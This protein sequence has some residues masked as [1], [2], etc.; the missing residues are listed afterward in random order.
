MQPREDIRVNS[1]SE[2]G[3]RVP[4]TKR[5]REILGLLAE[6]LSGAQIA[7]ELVLSPETVRTH[8]RNAMAKLGASTRSQ[9]VALALKG[10]EIHPEAFSGP[11]PERHGPSPAAA[12]SADP[13]PGLAAMLEGLVALYDVDGGGV[14]LAEEDGLSLRRVATA[15]GVD[16]GAE[17][18][19]VVALGD[20]PLGRAALERR[21]QLL[22]DA[23]PTGHSRGPLIAAPMVGGGRL[24]GVIALRPRSS[25][26]TGRSEM[27][28]LQAFANRVAEVVLDGSEVEDR[29]ARAMD[30]FSASWSAGPRM[31]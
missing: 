26:P 31:A 15:A 30:R 7:G 17:L 6:G 23:G 20:G 14:Y 29:L 4:L 18:A 19:E 12:T 16:S 1:A 24:L 5:E 22:Q 28:L 11:V 3:G 10:N 8:V 25:R 27:L 21:A 9:A 13:T 2:G